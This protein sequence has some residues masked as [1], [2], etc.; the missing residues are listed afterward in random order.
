MHNRRC[1]GHQAS[2]LTLTA[3]LPAGLL[4][5]CACHSASSHSF[6]GHHCHF[7]SRAQLTKRPKPEYRRPG[8]RMQTIADVDGAGAPRARSVQHGLIDCFEAGSKR[9]EAGKE[10]LLA[11]CEGSAVV[12]DG[13]KLMMASDKPIPGD[14]R[15]S[16]FEVAFSEG[17]VS[18]APSNYR[19][20]EAF[21]R[22]KKFEDASVDTF[23]KRVFFSTGFDRVMPGRK[24][25]N[26]YNMLLSYPVGRPEKVQVVSNEQPGC[27]TSVA[28]RPHLSAQLPTAHFPKGAPYYKIE[29]LAAV[30]EQRLFFGVRE[31]GASYKKFDY[32]VIILAGKYH[33]EGE[34]VQLEAPLTQ[35]YHLEELKVGGQRVGLSSL[36]YDPYG[37][38][39]YLLTSYEEERDDIDLGGYLWTLSWKQLQNN[40]PPSLVTDPNGAPL[41]FLNKPEGLTIL[42]PRRILVL[43]DDD[44]VLKREDQEVA[45]HVHQRGPQQTPYS[46]VDLQPPQVA[47][48]R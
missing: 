23:G 9:T 2:P 8:E 18:S 43:H 14:G 31:L 4:A 36:E 48:A 39:F 35:I 46:I 28:M 34:Q 40:L 16:I 24:L 1:S 27:Q 13:K 44:R 47:S 10:H 42:G 41:H 5:L 19:R 22:A 25:W 45:G 11:Y 6:F 20:E 12:W 32:A 17:K 33:F 7:S 37:D 15:S 30:P 26:P 21:M 29:G 3:L 38:R